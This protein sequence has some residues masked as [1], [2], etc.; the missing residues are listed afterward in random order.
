MSSVIFENENE[1]EADGLVFGPPYEYQ[2][3]L[4]ITEWD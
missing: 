3:D 2:N 1:V 4:E